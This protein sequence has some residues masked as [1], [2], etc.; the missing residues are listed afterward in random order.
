MYARTC[1]G[2]D[3]T[4]AYEEDADGFQFSRTRSKKVT[5]TTSATKQKDTPATEIIPAPTLVPPQPTG[6]RKRQSIEKPTRPT[7]PAEK[8]RRSARLSGGASQ[9]ES[10]TAT[11]LIPEPTRKV[12]KP[13]AK[14]ADTEPEEGK[15]EGNP[16]PKEREKDDVPPKETAQ[17]PEIRKPTKI[18]LPFA[19]TPIIM[20]NKEM[21]KHSG[22]GQGHRR[23]STGLR[24]RRASSLIESGTSNGEDMTDAQ[25]S[26]CERL[27]P[28]QHCLMLK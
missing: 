6:K 27:T 28:R 22:Q 14:H 17:P 11:L 21:R 13:R 2:T 19:D 8:R 16:P 12:F 1:F 25:L 20:R 26:T 10:E 4:A 7:S 18:A 3:A 24:G 23:S 9:T 5:S 15:Q